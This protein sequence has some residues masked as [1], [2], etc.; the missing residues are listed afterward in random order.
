VTL[1][2]GGGRAERPYERVIPCW[3][4]AAAKT[5]RLVR[6]LPK[7]FLW[8]LGL[9]SA[10]GIEQTTFTLGLLGQL[11]RGKFDLLHT[12][13]PQVAL[14]V[15][16]ARRLG[17]VRTLPI[18]GHATNEPPEFLSK[19][20]YVQHL[21][22]WSLDEIRRAG[23]WKSTWTAI[24][25][26]INTEVF[27]PRKGGSLRRELGIPEGATVLLCAAAIKIEHKRIDYLLREFAA[28]HNARPQLPVWLVVAGAREPD[29]DRL[30]SM[31]KQ[32]LG[33]RVRFLVS[34]PRQRMPELYGMADLFILSSLREMFGVVLV[35]ALASGLPCVVHE[36]PVIQSIVGPGGT[37]LNMTDP[38][39]LTA[40]LINYV[41][42]PEKRR[43]VGRR[44]REH[45]I[46]HFSERP[47]VDQICAY[48]HLVISDSLRRSSAASR[49]APSR[50]LHKQ[51][52][53]RMTTG[54]AGH[55]LPFEPS[56]A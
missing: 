36:H 46:T 48:Y 56:P 26:F 11:R 4:R 18:L 5:Q 21:S 37:A 19:I 28:F 51:D 1:F 12:Q 33:D 39:A 8:R 44:A 35:E 34:W 10:L 6:A 40:P 25:N 7:K 29:T 27:R 17:L 24:P 23:A 38:G 3:Q 13:E 32:L 52:S 16:W 15:Q 45:C 55:P 20:D 41:T 42:D 43:V 53:K 49:E 50:L 14:T 22:P 54:S 47:I 31:G 30:L 9:A 2:K